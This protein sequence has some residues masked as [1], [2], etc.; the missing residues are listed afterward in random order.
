MME[1][2]NK[3][4]IAAALRTPAGRAGG[5]LKDVRPDHLAAYLMGQ[6]FHRTGLDPAAVDQVIFGCVTQV[7]QQSTN[8]GRNAWLAAG[9]PEQVPAYTVDAQCGSSQVAVNMAAAL[10][11][12]GVHRI[13]LAGGA[14]SMS[15]VPLGANTETHGTPWG[16]WY[17]SRHRLAH[18]GVSAELIARRWGLGRRELDEFSYG[19]HV[20]AARAMAEGK[21]R[22]EIVPVPIPLEKEAR[23]GDAPEVFEADEGVRPEPDLDAMGRLKPVFQEDGIVTAGSSSQMSDGAA[24]VLVMSEDA[25][26]EWGLPARA[27]IV[28]QVSTSVEPTI[29]LTGP[30]P[31]TRAILKRAG[32]TA[33][34]ID[35]FEV[36]EAFAPVVLAWQEEIEPDPHR[37]NVNGGAIALG[38]PL[39]ATGARLMTTLLHELEHRRGRLGLQTMCC[40]GGLGIATIIERLD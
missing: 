18:Q 3:P 25:A 34:D 9:L 37:V 27:R 12:A 24:A 15:R 39:G 5:T 38:H 30:I 11:A 28:H 13:V 29:M 23:P 26:E 32:L 17:R 20:K 1:T 16:P 31:A 36:N 2:K 40:G 4:V 10:V 8:I 22:R 21:F 6:L 19:S 7:G 33:D 14:E 35:L